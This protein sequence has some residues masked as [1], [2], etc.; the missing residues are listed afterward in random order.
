M[1]RKTIADRVAEATEELKTLD[2]KGLY[3]WAIDND[4]DSASGFSRFKKA[5][6]EHGIDYSAMARPALD[7]TAE[8]TLYCDAKVS[9]DRFAVVF[10]QDDPAWYGRFFDEVSEQSQGEMAAAK[11]AVWYAA[12]AAELSR[13]TLLLNLFVDAQW[14]C[15]ANGDS[16]GGKAAELRDYARKLGVVLNV[17]WIPG[18]RNPADPFTVCGGFTKWNDTIDAARLRIALAEAGA[19]V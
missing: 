6:A 7:P 5:L 11:K 9:K 13:Q 12:K 17:E 3:D 10:G 15:C 8:M 2:R 1:A 14:L 19:R 18:A 16:G 4:L